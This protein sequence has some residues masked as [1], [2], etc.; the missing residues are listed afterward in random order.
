[1]TDGQTYGLVGCVVGVVITLHAW[2][3][4]RRLWPSLYDGSDRDRQDRP[5]AG[6]YL[7]GVVG[8]LLWPMAMIVYP[9]TVA[10]YGWRE[11]RYRR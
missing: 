4:G 8:G 5:H 11:R 9:V 10:V 1:M 7:V 6:D 2:R 3:S